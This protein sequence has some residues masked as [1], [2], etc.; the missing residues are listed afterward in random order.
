ML[1]SESSQTVTLVFFGIIVIPW[2]EIGFVHQ[3]N[4]GR[5]YLFLVHFPFSEMLISDIAHFLQLSRKLDDPVKFLFRSL[6]YVFGMINLLFTFFFI[7]SFGLEFFCV[8][9]TVLTIC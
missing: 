6:F 4:H 9:I 2:T 5:Q 3:S 1:A 7:P 8:F